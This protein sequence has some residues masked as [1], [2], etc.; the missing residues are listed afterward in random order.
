[1][2]RAN[3][4]SGLLEVLIQLFGFLQRFL[5]ENLSQTVSLSLT[6]VFS[7]LG[8]TGYRTYSLVRNQGS[9]RECSHNLHSGP[10]P[11]LHLVQQ[12]MSTISHSTLFLLRNGSNLNFFACQKST[13]LRE[14]HDVALFRGR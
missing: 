13:G 9:L 7:E 8:C 1:M 11:S 14:R 12:R 4:F 6:L 5:D 10:F 2:Q 3:D